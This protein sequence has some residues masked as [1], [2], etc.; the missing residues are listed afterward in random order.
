MVKEINSLSH[1]LEVAQKNWNI[2][3]AGNVARMVRKPRQARGRDRRLREGELDAILA[4]TQSK[5]LPS[6]V[7]L[8]VETA[9]R[10]GEIVGLQ[11]EYINLDKK[12]AKLLDTKKGEPR[13]VPLSAKAVAALLPLKTDTGPVFN[14]TQHAMS[15]AFRRDTKPCKC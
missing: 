13:H 4:A 2:G 9:M 1:L 14:L 8:A 3:L 11:W 12:V 5:S 15:V 10:M 7:I 6:V